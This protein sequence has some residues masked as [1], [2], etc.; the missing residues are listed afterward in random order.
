MFLGK[1]RKLSRRKERRL[2]A[3]TEEN[4]EQSTRS[5]RKSKRSKQ[6]S[7]P[8]ALRKDLGIVKQC[9]RS[10]AN[11]SLNHMHD[12]LIATLPP[13]MSL[14]YQ[15]LHDNFMPDRTT[16]SPVST[17]MSTSSTST[18]TSTTASTSSTTISSS[19]TIPASNIYPDL[20]SD[21]LSEMHEFIPNFTS[22]DNV[23]SVHTTQ[24]IY[25]PYLPPP[26]TYSNILPEISQYFGAFNRVGSLVPNLLNVNYF[27]GSRPPGTAERVVQ[28]ESSADA[29]N[30]DDMIPIPPPVLPL[31]NCTHPHTRLPEL[32]L[33]EFESTNWS[34]NSLLYYVFKGVSHI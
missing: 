30:V 29:N 4:P 21:Q 6:P 5:H 24:Y 12:H 13:E 32:T 34:K 31:I 1:E 25:N 22:I 15:K 19:T 7:E 9:L 16:S 27:Q 10:V 3:S 28:R 20:L 17:T 18:M 23:P 14:Y 33:E 11:T 8:S 2:K 26:R